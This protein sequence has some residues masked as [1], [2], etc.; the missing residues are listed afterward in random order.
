MWW[1]GS[2]QTHILSN[3]QDERPVD[4]G[5]SFSVPQTLNEIEAELMLLEEMK[6]VRKSTTR[7]P[8]IC[9]LPALPASSDDSRDPLELL[10]S[11]QVPVSSPKRSYWSADQTFW[12]KWNT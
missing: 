11:V 4:G 7:I 1:A 3:I 6:D 2:I 9:D 8:E 12:R 10:E 5:R